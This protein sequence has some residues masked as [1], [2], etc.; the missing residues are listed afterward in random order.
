MD[1]TPLTSERDLFV[2]E[3]DLFVEV[4]DRV[5]YCF[6][7]TPEERHSVMIV[8]TESN[9]RLGLVNENTPLA[10]ALLNSSVGDEPEIEVKGSPTKVVRV[11][12][13][14]RQQELPI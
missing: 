12:K 4:G 11:L 7:D 5:A 3:E 6:V 14:Q 2:S 10:K 8:D 13:I 1:A 9:P